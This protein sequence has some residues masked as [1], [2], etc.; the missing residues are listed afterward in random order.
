MYDYR[1]TAGG[2]IDGAI[3]NAGGVRAAIDKGEITRGEVLTAFPFLNA[4]C[5]ISFSGQQWWNIFEGI[6]SKKS[7]VTNHDVTSFVQVSK[8]IQVSYNPSKPIGSR[9]VSFQ[10]GSS[11][12]DLNKNY[13]FVSHFLRCTVSSTIAFLAADCD[14]SPHPRRLSISWRPAA[15][16]S[17]T[18]AAISARSALSTKSSSTTWGRINPSRFSSKD[19]SLS[20]LITVQIT[21]C[22]I[23]PCTPCLLLAWLCLSFR[24]KSP[25][26]LL[27]EY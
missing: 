9:L 19:G 22:R 3:I 21:K 20:L 7:T 2:K 12:I 4:V 26:G 5:D 25:A 11:P 16:S 27:G 23:Q 17:G 8:T 6:V 13:T 15:T 10:V 1:I 18:P 14:C 24:A